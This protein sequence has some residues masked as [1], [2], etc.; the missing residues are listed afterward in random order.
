[1]AV[2]VT[3]YQQVSIDRIQIIEAQ[4]GTEAH[5]GSALFGPRY[6]PT[7]KFDTQTTNAKFSEIN[8]TF[9]GFGHDIIHA[10]HL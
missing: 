3:T 7:T 2:G 10:F 8:S 1:M 9:V 5:Q 4:V 6:I